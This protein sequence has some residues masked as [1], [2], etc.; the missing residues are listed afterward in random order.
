MKLSKK[1]I[2]LEKERQYCF[3]VINLTQTYRLEEVSTVF[4]LSIKLI[5]LSGLFQNP[6]IFRFQI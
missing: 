4:S 5:I 6:E 3:L 2:S 1:F